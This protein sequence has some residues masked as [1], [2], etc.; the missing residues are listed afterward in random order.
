M[1][2]KNIKVKYLDDWVLNWVTRLNKVKRSISKYKLNK[3]EVIRWL[4]R[5]CHVSWISKISDNW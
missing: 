2:I 3:S 4:G 5:Q 1:M